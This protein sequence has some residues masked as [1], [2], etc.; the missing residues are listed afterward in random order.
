MTMTEKATA[1]RK[2]IKSTL[3][4]NSR[5]VSVKS[6]WSAI[7]VRCKAAGLDKKAIARIAYK[8]ESVHW[9]NGEILAGGND[10]VFVYDENGR[11]INSWNVA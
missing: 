4:Y 9:E 8:F 7:T 3:G 11:S 1:I 10:F 6:N 5:Q 2:E